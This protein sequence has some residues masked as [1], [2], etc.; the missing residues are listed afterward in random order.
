MPFSLEFS[1]DKVR[2]QVKLNVQDVQAKGSNFTRVILGCMAIFGLVTIG[3][4]VAMAVSPDC[5]CGT[6]CPAAEKVR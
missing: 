6:E 5:G 3:V 4:L 2:L 1:A